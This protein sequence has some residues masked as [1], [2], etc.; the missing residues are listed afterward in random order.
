MC[1][2]NADFSVVMPIHNE[3]EALKLS[4]PSVFR[5]D[6]AETILLFDDCT[7][8][9]YEVAVEIA[10]KTNFFEK[11]IFKSVS[12]EE[13]AQFL[14]R[15][16]FL[17][18]MGYSMAKCSKVLKTDADLV[19]DPKIKDYIPKLGKNNVGVITFEYLDFPIS[20]RHM[21]KRLLEKIGIPLPQ[22][23]SWLGGNILFFIEDWKK[24]FQ[25]RQENE[26]MKV[27]LEKVERGEDTLFH[28]LLISEQHRKSMIVLT[29]TLH[30]RPVESPK[31]H[32]LRGQISW[33][34]AKR[35]FSLILAQAIIFNR[36]NMIKGYLDAKKGIDRTY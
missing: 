14:F 13:G 33:K 35:P 16:T 1:D 26:S 15:P 22:S 18:R 3:S 6:P 27:D 36:L 25:K 7:D 4:L 28:K 30:L 9:S 31:R 5:L 8:D 17:R 21:I 19:L 23:E 11:T 29:K 34:V 12:K 2:K 24:A 10:K 32:Y 20:Y